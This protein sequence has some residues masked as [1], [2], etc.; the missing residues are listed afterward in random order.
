MLLR[1][2][3]I[4]DGIAEILEAKAIKE[5]YPPQEESIGPALAGENL[6]LAIPTA[7][8]KSLVAYLAILKSVLKGGKALY[9]VPL[10]SLAVEKYEDLKEFEQ[11]GVRVALSMGD[12]DSS[13][14]TLQS[15]DVII[16]TSEKADSLLRHRSHWLKQLSVVVADEIHLINDPGRGPTLEVTLAKL[17]QVNP[18]AQVIALSATIANSEELSD[19]LQA[20]HIASEWRPVPLKEGVYFDGTITF[21]D[22]SSRVLSHEGDDIASLVRDTLREG[23]QCLIFVNTRRSTETL[24][25][26]LLPAARPYLTEEEVRVLSKASEVMIGRQEEPTSIASRLARAIKG[27]TSFHNA[28]LTNQQRKVVEDLFRQGHLKCIAATPTLASGINLPARRVIIRDTRRYDPNY[29][30]DYI[31][32]LEIKQMCGRAGRPQYDDYGE[33]VLLARHEE[34][35]EEMLE[36]YILAGPES[37]ESKLGS[38]PA[39][40]MHLLAAIATGHVQTEVELRRFMERTFYAHQGDVADI[41]ERIDAVLDFLEREDFIVQGEA[42]RSTLFGKRTSDLYVDPLSSVA[43]RDALRSPKRGT[44][45]SYLHALCATPDMSNLYLGRKDYDWVEEKASTAELLVE[46][47][48]YDFLLAEV[49]TASLLEDWIEERPEDKVTKKFRVGPGDIRRM[50]GMAQWLLYATHEL[51]RLFSKKRMKTLARLMPRIKY[52]VKEELLRLVDV[53]GIGRVRARALFERGL[54]NT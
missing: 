51:A 8:G 24:A 41:E 40:R 19:W 11:L 18:S 48:D 16:A 53:R 1:D 4:D 46:T 47:E 22:L 23:G 14:P 49:K 25:R 9:I 28:G 3:D 13:E 31:P 38:E 10:R 35:V 6:V 50:V 52:G 44:P 39:L 37:I 33:A 36:N 7:S 45:F 26:K 2:L 5:L 54:R 29:G 15:Y 17:R 21:A 12:Y 32:V 20:R 34:D 27:G 43:L 30:F 42:L